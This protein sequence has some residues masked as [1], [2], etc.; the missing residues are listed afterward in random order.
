M[1][2]GLKTTKPLQEPVSQIRPLS[3][4][5]LD[6]R[7]V[8]WRGSRFWGWNITLLLPLLLRDEKSSA[9]GFR[10]VNGCSVCWGGFLLPQSQDFCSPF[11]LAS[12][13]DSCQSCAVKCAY[14]RRCVL[15][16]YRGRQQKDLWVLIKGGCH[17]FCRL[18]WIFFPL[19]FALMSMQEKNIYQNRF[20]FHNILSMTLL[21][22]YTY[23]RYINRNLL[24]TI[25]IHSRIK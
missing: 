4:R 25:K 9:L 10:A 16:G 22:V 15:W 17:W 6:N 13:C 3:A 23:I 5:S 20:G 2:F 11:H 7:V 14:S 21:Y 8:V 12:S 24:W 18:E 1:C 19:Q